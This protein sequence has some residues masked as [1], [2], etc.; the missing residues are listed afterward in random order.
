MWHN[1]ALPE[2]GVLSG[3]KVV[4]ASSSLAGPLGPT[5]FAE[6]GADVVWIE[7]A[8]APDYTRTL[9]NIQPE[10]ERRN[11]RAMG[12]K[13]GSPEGRQI[14]L[15]LIKDADVFIESS[16]GGQFDRFDLSD[17]VM[18]E[19]NP[20]LVIAHISGYGQTGLPEY[21][22][23]GGFD[24]TAQAF[25]GYM[26]ENTNGGATPPYAVG[27]Y[28]ADY[29][30][31][32]WT[33]LAVLAAVRKAD[34]T[35]VG[36]SL[37]IAQYELMM[38]ASIFSVDYFTFHREFPKTGE[39]SMIAGWGGFPCKDGKI[40]Y[41]CFSGASVLK[42]VCGLLGLE[43]GSD[44]FPAEV[45]LYNVETESGKAFEKAVME[46]LAGKTVDEAESEMLAAGLPVSK[47]NS[48]EDVENNPHVQARGVIEE[49]ETLKGT[50]LRA[51]GP[52]PKFKKHP[53]RVWR[54]APSFGE[55]NEEI[56]GELGYSAEQIADL[57]DK[58]VINKDFDLKL[59]R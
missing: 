4:H 38:R 7:N 55:N 31:A 16:K 25:S 54:P 29:I 12:I 6:Y 44:S 58:G 11:Q 46:Y 48:W 45:G 52:L 2:F 53:G 26:W 33:A 5:I 19:V 47:V 37:D 56:L 32:L 21:V 43:Y 9:H 41:C 10:S 28:V 36:D 30:T 35:G 42:K 8:Q 3:L 23:R 20:K 18:W 49:W 40:L 14:V 57:Y 59:S 39:K 50:K 22:G 1:K 27:P 51:V 13:I 24:A 34:E 17:E 15:D